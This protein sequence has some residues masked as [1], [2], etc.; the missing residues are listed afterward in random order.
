MRPGERFNPY[1]RLLGAF[2]PNAI[3]RNPDLS[4]GAKVLYGRLAQFSGDNGRCYPSH[5]KIAAE[6]G[7]KPRNVRNLI[8]ELLE[9]GLLAKEA[10][11]PHER[12]KLKKST[13]YFFLWHICLD[14]Q[15]E[16]KSTAESCPTDDGSTAESCPSSTAE[17]CRVVRQNIAAEENHLKELKEKKNTHHARACAG[18]DSSHEP[19]DNGV[20]VCNSSLSES[21]KEDG[22]GDGS[23]EGNGHGTTTADGLTDEQREYITWACQQ[24]D[25]RNPGALKAALTSKA[26]RGEL[27]IPPEWIPST[28]SRLTDANLRA[29]SEWAKTGLTG[30]DLFRGQTARRLLGNDATPEVTLRISEGLLARDQYHSR[31][32]TAP[33]PIVITSLDSTPDCAP[34]GPTPE[35][36]AAKQAQ[37]EQEERQKRERMQAEREAERRYEEKRRREAEDS[38]ARN[39]AY[40]A[41]TAAAKDLDPLKVAR[42][43]L[44]SPT[45]VKGLAG[46]AKDI[47]AATVEKL[48]PELHH[49]VTAPGTHYTG[50]GAA[51]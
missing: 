15:Q 13:T 27:V 30:Y 2:I 41:L 40:L 1:K 26:K 9:Y 50:P 35:E 11:T 48:W 33:A 46:L 5:S 12:G 20:C 23:H 51:V 7:V 39:T 45:K 6:L 36:L 28:G 49:A 10:P 19:E 16:A 47:I 14:E 42:L 43:A 31:E 29:A 17:S 21:G 34:T 4:F 38:A 18:K 3:L 37:R 32:Q 25:V 44:K 8:K 22:N 24:L